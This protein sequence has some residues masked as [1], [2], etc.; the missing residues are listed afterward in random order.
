M[1]DGAAGLCDSYGWADTDG[2]DGGGVERKEGEKSYLQ[3]K[4]KTS[5]QIFEFYK[6]REREREEG[7]NGGEAG[8][9]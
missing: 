1:G 7:E 6:M 9:K 4:E 3:G 5:K 8:C 2:Q